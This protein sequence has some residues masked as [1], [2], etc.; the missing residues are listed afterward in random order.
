MGLTSVVKIILTKNKITMADHTQKQK[1]DQQ[2]TQPV[3]DSDDDDD[4]LP[5][6]DIVYTEEVNAM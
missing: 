3:S 6:E 1:L 4:S 5:D 2:E